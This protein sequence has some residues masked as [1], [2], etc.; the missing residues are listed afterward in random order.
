MADEIAACRNAIAVHEAHLLLGCVRYHGAHR[1][2]WQSLCILPPTSDADATP[3][4]TLLLSLAAPG[5]C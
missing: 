5:V 4:I 2:S 3:L 1:P